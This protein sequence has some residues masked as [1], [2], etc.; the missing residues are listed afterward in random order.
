MV[1]RR[2][3][4]ANGSSLAIAPQ[5]LMMFTVIIY[6]WYYHWQQHHPWSSHNT[7]PQFLKTDPQFLK[8]DWQHTRIIQVVKQHKGEL[9]D[10]QFL[11][12]DPQFLKKAPPLKIGQFRGQKRPE[13]ARNFFHSS[14]TYIKFTFCKKNGSNRPFQPAAVVRRIYCRLYGVATTN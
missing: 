12:K 9:Q 13:N 3:E 11:K 1:E 4:S 8:S 5:P 2:K 10:P 7:D 14:A 6:H